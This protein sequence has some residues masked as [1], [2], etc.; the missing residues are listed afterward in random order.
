[1]LV[2]RKR[3][4]TVVLRLRVSLEQEES[5]CWHGTKNSRRRIE[6]P[7]DDVYAR[8]KALCTAGLLNELPG[9]CQ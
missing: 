5:G 3:W 7:D 4:Q 1:M 9:Q 6:G 8:A 2:G